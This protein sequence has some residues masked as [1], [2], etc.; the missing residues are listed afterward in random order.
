MRA[1]GSVRIARNRPRGRR[2]VVL[3]SQRP[4]VRGTPS[5]PG[6][7]RAPAATADSTSRSK[8]A[9]SLSAVR[10]APMPRGPGL[11]PPPG[12]RRSPVPAFGR[13]RVGGTPTCH[14]YTREW[15]SMPS[16]VV[17]CSSRRLE[18]SR[19]RDTGGGGLGLATARSIVRGHGGDTVSANRAE[20]GLRT[21]LARPGAERA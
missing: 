18:A 2:L 3:R 13:R 1:P 6:T 20:G 5:A 19:S 17:K 21:T 12:K 4:F 8:P 16:P 15:R 7:L 11:R 10:P 9:S 14:A